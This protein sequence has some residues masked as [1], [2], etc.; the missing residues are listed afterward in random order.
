[1]T[2]NPAPASLQFLA[3]GTCRLWR[4]TPEFSQLPMA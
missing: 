4:N 2:I 1:M 3:D